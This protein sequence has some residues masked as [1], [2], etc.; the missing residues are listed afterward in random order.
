[1]FISPLTRTALTAEP[2]TN[3]SGCFCGLTEPTPET[4]F[5]LVLG[6]PIRM[7]LT[8]KDAAGSL[9]PHFPYLSLPV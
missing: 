5:Q 1:M 9:R 2:G 6:Q 3:G 8:E 4:M 7:G